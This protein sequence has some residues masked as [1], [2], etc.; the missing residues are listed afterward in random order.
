MGTIIYKDYDYTL[1]KNTNLDFDFVENYESIHQSITTIIMTKKGSRT[2]FQNPYFGSN[3]H[4]ILFEKMSLFT[5][6]QIKNEIAL[7]LELWE[8]RI[9]IIQIIVDAKQEDNLYN[10]TIQYKIVELNIEDE[11]VLELGVV[12]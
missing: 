4:K 10:V 5:S 6:I 3:V 11:L 7:A 9:E 8:Q 1:P 2:Q 12:K